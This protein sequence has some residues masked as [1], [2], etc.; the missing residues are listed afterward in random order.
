M[1]MKHGQRMVICTLACAAL[2]VSSTAASGDVPSEPYR[3]IVEHN[4]FG[5]HPILPPPEINTPPP[6][7]P[8]VFLTGITTVLGHKCALL[9]TTPPAKPGEAAKEQ[10]FTLAEGQREGEIEVLE[11][12]ELARTVKVNNYGAITT[13]DFDKDGVKV[14]AMPPGPGGM[15]PGP[16]RSSV[17]PP[18]GANPMPRSMRLPAPMG[19]STSTGGAMPESPSAIPIYGSSAPALAAGGASVPVTGSAAA[20]MQAQPQAAA[21]AASSLTA[22]QQFLMVEAERMRLQQKGLEKRFSPVPPTPLTQ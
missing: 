2:W 11:I 22:E 9:K 8:R 4:V 12:N 6:P 21:S 20:Q 13:L 17:V 15:L 1:N 5:L 16:A 19:D 18:R 3:G 10:A 7:T 14:A